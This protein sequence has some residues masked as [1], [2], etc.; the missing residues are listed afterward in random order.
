MAKTTFRYSEAFKR[1]VVE[2]Y[3]SGVFDGITECRRHYGIKGS[4]T[5]FDWLK[6]Y[7]KNYKSGKVV[8][9]ELMNE[10][11]RIKELELELKRTK[12]ALA[13]TRV[14]EVM[15]QAYFELLCEQ[16]GI[17]DVEEFKKKVESKLLDEQKRSKVTA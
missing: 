11:D 7:G 17:C 5:I 1:K 8:R 2:D 3:E 15:N 10:R 4:G 9:V 14:A 13:E 12:K 16:Q 6:K